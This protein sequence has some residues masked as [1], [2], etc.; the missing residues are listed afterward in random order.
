MAKNLT[1]LPWNTQMEIQSTSGSTI[2]L[3]VRQRAKERL[4]WLPATWTKRVFPKQFTTLVQMA[5]NQ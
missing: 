3:G 5:G 1:L 2:L 4:G